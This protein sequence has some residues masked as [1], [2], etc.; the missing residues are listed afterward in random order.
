V[1]GLFL[2]YNAELTKIA[3][4]LPKQIEHIALYIMQS[5]GFPLQLSVALGRR[6]EN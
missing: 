1:D 4:N 6:E 2:G 5:G 3:S